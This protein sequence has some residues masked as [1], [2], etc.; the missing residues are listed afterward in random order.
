MTRLA[1]A[2]ASAALITLTSLLAPAWAQAPVEGELVLNPLYSAEPGSAG[3]RLRLRYPSVDYE[4]EYSAIKRYLPP[5]LTL[6]VDERG[7]PAEH[8]PE[9]ERDR[10]TRLGVLLDVPKNYL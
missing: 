9:H 1:T 8:L 7:R 10:L 2:L 3:A 4:Q 5:T 6:D